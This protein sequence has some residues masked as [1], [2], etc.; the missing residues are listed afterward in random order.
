MYTCM[1]VWYIPG[2]DLDVSALLYL[3]KLLQALSSDR[4]RIWFQDLQMSW[5]PVKLRVL[6][7]LTVDTLKL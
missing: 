5:M 6:V 3:P 4:N 1:Y 7:E 2:V